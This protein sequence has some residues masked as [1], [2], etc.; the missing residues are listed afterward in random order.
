MY[1]RAK[2]ATK[3]TKFDDARHTLQFRNWPSDIQGVSRE[4]LLVL[5]EV[6]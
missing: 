4:L 2:H 3:Q 6:I 1:F 5:L